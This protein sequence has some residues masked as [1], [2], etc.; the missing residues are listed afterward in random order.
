MKYYIILLVIIIIIITIIAIF[1]SNNNN[2]NKEPFSAPSDLSIKDDYDLQD[3]FTY[4]F[5]IAVVPELNESAEKDKFMTEDCK[6]IIK[7]RDTVKSSMAKY[8]KEYATDELKRTFPLLLGNDF[9][10]SVFKK[11]GQY[12]DNTPTG[13][14]NKCEQRQLDS[15][16][17]SQNDIINISRYFMNLTLPTKPP[18]TIKFPQLFG[19]PLAS[20]DISTEVNFRAFFNN[21]YSTMIQT[22]TP[23][24]D[25]YT[26][27]AKMNWCSIWIPSV[28]QPLIDN[29]SMTELL[30]NYPNMLTTQYDVFILYSLVSSASNLEKINDCEEP[31]PKLNTVKNNLALKGAYSDVLKYIKH[32][33]GKPL[34][35]TVPV[36]GDTKETG[37]T[38]S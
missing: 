19:T 37:T 15:M 4:L 34:K 25:P 16:Y 9:N 1:L 17:D 22:Q 2:N 12:I 8:A 10:I 36:D 23:Q 30:L 7:T 6:R 26:E 35:S 20:M 18:F 11:L 33:Y 28:L 24:G 21:A 29:S 27:C 31:D 5:S 38:F 32:F 14:L 13:N 3:F